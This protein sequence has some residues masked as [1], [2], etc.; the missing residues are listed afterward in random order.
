MQHDA[1]PF[2]IIKTSGILVSLAERSSGCPPSPRGREQP[3]Q[4]IVRGAQHGRSLHILS[5]TGRTRPM[6]HVVASLG[7]GRVVSQPSLFAGVKGSVA[8]AIAALNPTIDKSALFAKGLTHI[9]TIEL[10]FGAARTPRRSGRFRRPSERWP[11]CRGWAEPRRRRRA[12]AAET[13]LP[14]ATPFRS[15]CAAAAGGPGR[16]RAGGRRRR[17]RGRSIA[18]RRAGRRRA[19]PRAGSAARP[20]PRRRRPR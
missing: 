16:A 19:N 20:R 9:S 12:R 6:N 5:G 1:P 11:G 15:P 18:I 14:L 13:S 10:I 8:D 2:P 4:F 17:R 3:A 7:D